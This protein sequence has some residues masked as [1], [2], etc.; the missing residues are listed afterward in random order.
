MKFGRIRFN[1]PQPK[2]GQVESAV[3]EI[4]LGHP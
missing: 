1:W 3:T 2:F 4:W